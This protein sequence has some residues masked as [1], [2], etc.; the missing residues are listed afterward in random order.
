MRALVWFRKWALPLWALA[1]QFA[2]PA[3]GA[4]PAFQDTLAQRVQVCFACHGEQGRAGPDGYYPR[5][6][7]KPAGYL[8][9]QLRYFQTGQRQHNLMARLVANLSDA[10]LM[11]MAQYFSALDLP[12]AAPLP[13]KAPAALLARGRQLAL[14][15]D[16]AL[17]LPA[18]TSCHGKALTGQLPATPGLLGLSGDYLGAQLGA[19]R[20][21]ARAAHGPDCMAQTAQRLRP[22]DVAAL[23][24]WLSSQVMPAQSAPASPSTRADL[25]CGSQRPV[26]VFPLSTP[27]AALPADAAAAASAS[28]GRYLAVLGNCQACHTR[29]GGQPFAGGRGIATPFG[30]VYSSNLT[31]AA[32]GLRGW[33]A[34]DFWRAM[35]HGQSRDG[36]LLN[37]AFP[38]AN[39]RRISRADSDA[40]YRFFMGLQPVEAAVPAHAL[41]WPLNTQLALRAWRWL[42]APASEAASDSPQPP[43]RTSAGDA[44]WQRGAYLVE[45]LGHCSACHMP[46]NALG[47][48]AD[49]FSLAGG[50][51]AGQSWYAPS[52]LDPAEAG[53]QNKPAAQVAQLLQTGRGGDDRSSG[54]M[55]EV[56]RHSL[57]HWKPQD[58][59]AMV[60]YLQR[61]PRLASSSRE[62]AP[63][64]PRAVASRGAALYERHCADCHGAQG[65]GVRASDGNWAYPPLLGNRT[66]LQAVPVNLVQTVLYG[67]FGPST[68]GNP[69]PFGMPP[70]VLELSEQEISDVVSFIRSAWGN[71]AAPVSALDVQRLRNGAAQ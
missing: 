61:L 28:A 18:C 19:W 12:Y 22:G 27:P 65:Q 45:G 36:R 8:Y 41:R 21:G 46:R 56:V 37:P 11:D 13:P 53:V 31:P 39:F 64:A 29:A 4:A 26:M 43:A 24:A 62:P 7:G 40:L 54:P 5:I 59:D 50:F 38:Y 47:G 1:A 25:A 69:Q 70:Y 35:H 68:S 57:Q 66:V 15:G 55:A 67:G 30:T 51:M 52:L 34:E 42:Y 6:A 17:A 2:A 10:Y 3:F 16:Q 23:S 32:S 48:N 58:M 71:Q 20:T 14:A 33:T 60:A 9:N 44:Q 63:A 49:M